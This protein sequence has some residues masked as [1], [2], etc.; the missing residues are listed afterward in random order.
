[1]TKTI[2]INCDVGEVLANDPALLPLVSSCNIACGGHA[3]DET[4]M[5]TTIRIAKKYGVRIGAHPSYPDKENFGR[6]V[7]AISAGELQRSLHKQLEI[8]ATIIEE[9]QAEWHHIKPHGALYNAIAKDNALATVYLEAIER[10]APDRYLYVPFQSRIAENAMNSGFKIKYEAFADR[11]YNEDLSLV[12]RNLENAVITSPKLVLQ[13]LLSMVLEE[14]VKTISG[15]VR[16]IQANTFC[17]H[18]DTATA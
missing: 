2:D 3:G 12:S 13:H 7:L 9:E 15:E 4:S 5:R 1:M 6:K 18:G 8:F 17:I 16:P 10:F 14:K 11:N